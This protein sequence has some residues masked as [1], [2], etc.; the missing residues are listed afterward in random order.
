MT[1]SSLTIVTIGGK[2]YLVPYSPAFTVA[3]VK[4]SL[5]AAEGFPALHQV[6]IYKGRK[7]G[8][9][10]CLRE[11]DIAAGDKVHLIIANRALQLLFVRLDGNV[12]TL[13]VL[14]EDSVGMIKR[15]LSRKVRR[16]LSEFTVYDSFKELR[17]DD[18][19][20]CDAGVTPLAH[21]ELRCQR[22]YRS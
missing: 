5:Q 4:A 20:L 15:M 10:L 16:E 17:N 6:L 12:Y 21:L 19:R 11:L 7:L 3:Q 18:Q 13:D 8:D 14:M 2:H 22:R 1:E 9:H